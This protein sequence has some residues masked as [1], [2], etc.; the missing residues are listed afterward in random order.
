MPH[1]V[2]VPNWTGLAELT[3][4]DPKGND[5]RLAR[6]MRCG[7]P[8]TALQDRRN[9]ESNQ[10][11]ASVFNVYALCSRNGFITSIPSTCRPSTCRAR[12]CSFLGILTA[13]LLPLRKPLVIA[14][15]EYIGYVHTVQLVRQNE[16]AARVASFLGCGSVALWFRGFGLKLPELPF[17]PIWCYN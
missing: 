9:I 17:Q 1:C 16:P 12:N 14:I 13:W 2:L 3:S 4:C 7:S 10:R 15:K 5:N 11:P 6:K 8:R